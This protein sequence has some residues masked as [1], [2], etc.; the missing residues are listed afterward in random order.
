M[1][2]NR[3]QSTHSA[4]NDCLRACRAP[5]RDRGQRCDSGSAYPPRSALQRTSRTM[6]STT[7][8]PRPKTLLEKLHTFAYFSS[9]IYALFIVLLATPYFQ[10]Q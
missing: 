10:R 3:L 8:A 5:D 1:A 6:T 2:G 9:G 7:D 4:A